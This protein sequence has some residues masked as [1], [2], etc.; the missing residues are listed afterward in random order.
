MPVFTRIDSFL[1]YPLSV[2]FTEKVWRRKMESEKVPRL[3]AS[4]SW[5]NKH[6]VDNGKLRQNWLIAVKDLGGEEDCYS[7][8]WEWGPTKGGALMISV[9]K[10]ERQSNYFRHTATLSP[11][12][13]RKNKNKIS[14]VYFRCQNHR[15]LSSSVLQGKQICT[16]ILFNTTFCTMSVNLI[17][18]YEMIEN[19][20]N[21]YLFQVV[22]CSN[23]IKINNSDSICCWLCPTVEV[24]T[25]YVE[26]CWVWRD[27]LHLCWLSLPV[28]LVMEVVGIPQV[29]EMQQVVWGCEQQGRRQRLSMVSSPCYTRT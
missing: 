3:P 6:W 16:L 5:C 10:L 11:H 2:L 12:I 18:I 23:K 19:F 17:F 28:S 24:S 8:H 27:S 26:T 29:E 7:L 9:I 21:R 20:I 13:G 15:S 22:L 4:V 25:V 1:Q 14:E